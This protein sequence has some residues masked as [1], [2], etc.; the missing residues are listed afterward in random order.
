MNPNFEQEQAINSFEGTCLSAG[1]GAGKTFV[2][3]EH[4]FALITKEIKK[5]DQSQIDIIQIREIIKKVVVITFTVKAAEELFFRLE[6]RSK[7]YALEHPWG[8]LVAENINFCFVG[9]IHS[10][11]YLIL[12]DLNLADLKSCEI[13]D[14]FILKAKVQKIFN[15]FVEMKGDEI[16]NREELDLIYKSL[17]E[18]VADPRKRFSWNQDLSY[19]ESYDEEILS[20]LE[21]TEPVTDISFTVSAK[22]LK[23]EL[24]LNDYLVATKVKD[25][26]DRYKA[27]LELFEKYPRLVSPKKDKV[28]AIINFTFLNLKEF[29]KKILAFS[30]NKKLFCENSAASFYC[31]LKEAVCYIEKYYY[32]DGLIGFSDLEY[33]SLKYKD[34]LQGKIQKLIVDEFQDVSKTQ[35]DIFSNLI[36]SDYSRIYCVGDKKQAI[37]SFRG[38]EVSV[39]ERFENN[40]NNSFQLESNYRSRSEIVEF[41]NSI[42][43]EILNV[44]VSQ[45]PFL[46]NSG[47]VRL[48]EFD[49][50][51]SDDENLR[52][53]EA[54]AT[55]EVLIKNISDP[56]INS[57]AVLYRFMSASLSLVE[58]L[59]QEDKSFKATLKIKHSEDPLS[60]M[61]YLLTDYFLGKRKIE[62]VIRLINA[63]FELLNINC[64]VRVNDLI[65]LKEQIQVWGIYHSYVQFLLKMSIVFTYSENVL[66]KIYNICTY[67]NE[68]ISLINKSSKFFNNDV[69]KFKIQNAKGL[70]KDLEI[71]STHA[72]KGLE[73][74]SVIVGAIMT[75]ARGRSVKTII[76]EKIESFS[77]LDKKRNKVF[78]PSLF[79]E[80]LLTKDKNYLESMRLFYVAATRAKI[81]LD[82]VFFPEY[83]KKLSDNSWGRVL[84]N[85]LESTNCQFI[86]R[87]IETKRNVPKKSR[88]LFHRADLGII[89][90]K[91]PL[92]VGFIPEMSV[93]KLA[94]IV[95]CP[96]K[97]YFSE[98]LKISSDELEIFCLKSSPE[99]IEK[100]IVSDSKRG[101][102]IHKVIESFLLEGKENKKYEN[103]LK[104]VS[105]QIKGLENLKKYIEKNIKFDI[106]GFVINGTIDFIVLDNKSKTLEIWDFKTGSKDLDKEPQYKAQ[107]KLYLY[108]FSKEI[109]SFDYKLK[110]KIV[111]VDEELVVEDD[112]ASFEEI[113][114]DVFNIF[115]MTEKLSIENN[116]HCAKC[117]YLKICQSSK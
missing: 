74:D 17:V 105:S 108:G 51:Y 95:L 67:Y 31:L 12:N 35:G 38:G 83:E 48:N 69:L 73:F 30:K 2:I 10:L 89:E 88:P 70:E 6:K 65:D 93:T 28:E 46:E 53:L 29:K 109:K 98:V 99:I 100:N 85:Q 76:G 16:Q 103:I 1:A 96:K 87:T 11:C 110:S 102:L 13:T 44:K 52:E 32:I 115:K 106:E 24:L 21:I 60:S 56:N 23:W 112:Y 18:I 61:F 97:F 19:H 33:L 114:N 62:S 39:F 37:Y 14:D 8:K 75:N 9:T 79:N 64:I 34:K 49:N 80:H 90:K 40:I 117:E 20:F 54:L 36:D 50:S 41:N 57:L 111:Y 7:S 43:S 3:V 45:K 78:S 66:K 22:P 63:Y 72:S 4:F 26:L 27:Y 55:Y 42:F 84:I 58:I 71:M 107:L 5:I 82:F 116:N 113:S 81:N 15:S 47:F 92:Y 59:I 68:D 86:K 104:F 25:P 91:P 101:I 94:S 77:I